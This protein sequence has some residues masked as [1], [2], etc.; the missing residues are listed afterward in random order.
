MKK[1]LVVLPLVAL[2]S[3]CGG[4]GDGGKPSATASATISGPGISGSAT[5]DVV[6]NNVDM[7]NK[8]R[9][10]N[11]AESVDVNLTGT[12]TGS[13]TANGETHAVNLS[14]SGIVTL[15]ATD[16]RD[17]QGLPTSYAFNQEICDRG[18]CYNVTGEYDLNRGNLRTDVDVVNGRSSVFFITNEG[19]GTQTALTQEQRDDIQPFYDNYQ[20]RGGNYAEFATDFQNG[21]NEG[22]TGTG[23]ELTVNRD[24]D[25]ILDLLPNADG[26]TW[27][28]N[29][30]YSEIYNTNLGDGIY[31]TSFGS[32]TLLSL[33]HI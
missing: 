13:L 10:L 28:N 23:F 25:I 3:A 7:L 15:Y 26:Y 12:L 30:N 9:Y 1:S 14:E 11:G 27:K 18:T 19:T 29:Q 5:V 6:V 32:G 24:D 20:E 31:V 16:A 17:A 8:A 22:W 4:G 33:I 21:L 2:V